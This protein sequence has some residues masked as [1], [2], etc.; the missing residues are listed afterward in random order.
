MWLGKWAGSGSVAILD[1]AFNTS[2]RLAEDDVLLA[3]YDEEEYEGAAFV[4]FQHEGHLY[5][6]NALHGSWYGLEGQ[7]EPE[8]TTPKALRYRVRKGSFGKGVFSTE[9]LAVLDRWEAEH[10]AR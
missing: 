6:V 9:L 5:E 10:A 7:W 3:W 1:E 4:L 2:T 8:E